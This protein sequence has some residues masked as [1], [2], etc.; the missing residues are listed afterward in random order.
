[1]KN[2]NTSP[3]RGYSIT[4]NSKRN[5]KSDMI[6]G[7][8]KNIYKSVKKVIIIFHMLLASENNISQ[9]EF[10]AD[11]CAPFAGLSRK[12]GAR[13]V[14][15]LVQRHGCYRLHEAAQ[16]LP[17]FSSSFSLRPQTIL[18]I[19]PPKKINRIHF[20]QFKAF[21]YIGGRRTTGRWPR[22]TRL[23]RTPYCRSS[24]RCRQT[25]Q[26]FLCMGR[27]LW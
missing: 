9:F 22:T 21:Y 26:V 3:F 10:L 25:G 17:G 18:K 27:K 7:F 20:Y 5:I 1:M 4:K 11:H 6:S 16:H 14:D 13:V 24:T 8:G 2:V 15:P 23:V 12:G 19:W